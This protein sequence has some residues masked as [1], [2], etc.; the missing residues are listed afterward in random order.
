MA[1]AQSSGGGPIDSTGG[2][3][4]GV[5]GP[6]GGTGG[7]YP[8]P[9]PGWLAH[10]KGCDSGAGSGAGSS[11]ARRPA[12]GPGQTAVWS[13]SG[14]AAGRAAGS[15]SQLVVPGW[16]HSAGVDGSSSDGQMKERSLGSQLCV[17]SSNGH[18]AAGGSGGACSGIGWSNGASQIGSCWAA[19]RRYSSPN[20][21]G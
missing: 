2:G 17:V 14:A 1:A 19:L 8:L 21:A 5:V 12:S 18:V 3:G 11:Q 10:G 4:A 20:N 16:S 15:S 7:A 9:P 13:G 6:V